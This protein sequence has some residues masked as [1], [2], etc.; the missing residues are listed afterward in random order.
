MHCALV[1]YSRVDRVLV[2]GIRRRH[3][4]TVELIEP[5]VTVLFPV[6]GRVGEEILVAHIDS[7]LS[8]HYS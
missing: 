3:D 8:P 4:P 2:D 5:H 1:F 7:A 6:P